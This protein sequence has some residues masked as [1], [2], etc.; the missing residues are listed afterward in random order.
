MSPELN[1][2]IQII[3]KINKILL[4]EYSRFRFSTVR[5]KK[6]REIVTPVDK[7]I[8]SLI[9]KE[10]LNKFPDH[11][12]VSEE[13]RAINNPGTRKWFIDPLDGTTNFAY[14]FSEFATCLG[15]MDKNYYAG[16][17]GLPFMKEIYFAEKGIGAF[18]N[19]K[20]IKVSK[21]KGLNETM[22]LL[23]AGHSKKAKIKFNNFFYKNSINF[24][25]FRFLAVAGVELTAIASGKAD[26]CIITEAHPWDVVA[27]VAILR[28]A[29]GKVTNFKG[30]EWTNKDTSIVASNG[31]IHDKIVAMTKN[32]S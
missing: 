26:A 10:I 31:L 18:C 20:K 6:Q 4:A 7:K 14:G 5:Y 19:G 15:I 13:A 11:D 21:R 27:G 12:I 22:I 3:K 30:E 8:N 23:C 1:C 16:V 32:I 28:E 29:G 25:H 9:I 17:V 2:A 24:P